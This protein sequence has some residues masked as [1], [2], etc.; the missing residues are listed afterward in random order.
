MHLQG[1][2]QH[3]GGGARGRAG[4]QSL[5]R[6]KT[7]LSG[8]NYHRLLSACTQALP[9]CL[10]CW[11]E[12]TALLQHMLRI[13]EAVRAIISF[14]FSTLISSETEHISNYA[15]QIQTETSYTIFK[16]SPV[17][18]RP[19]GVGSSLPIPIWTQSDLAGGYSGLISGF[20]LQGCKPGSL[21][22]NHKYENE[23]YVLM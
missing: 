9:S 16:V 1:G 8:K 13:G 19:S 7:R 5:G 3:H 10:R 18:T 12:C 2:S 22:H 21:S 4:F 20:L 15:C 23:N 17:D 11:L 6:R 14:F